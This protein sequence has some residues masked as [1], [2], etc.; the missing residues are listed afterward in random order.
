MS[1]IFKKLTDEREVMDYVK[2]HKEIFNLS[3][4]EAYPASFFSMLIRKEHPLGIV[5][6]CYVDDELKGVAVGLASPKQKSVYIP[7]AG[8][9]K[10]FQGGR[11]AFNLFM[12]L[13]ENAFNEGYESIFGI[14]DPLQSNVGK[15]HTHLGSVFNKIVTDNTN[16][17][18]VVKLIFEA[19]VKKINGQDKI[20]SSIKDLIKSIPV[21]DDIGSKHN[22]LLLQIPNNFENL[23]AERLAEAKE[24]RK[25]AN[26]IF[27]YYID[28]QNYIVTKCFS[29]KVNGEKKTYYLFEKK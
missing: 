6:G 25:K 19:S 14:I 8:I 5:I 18:P 20:H 4:L 15:V 12:T 10:E 29:Q 7:F 22:K 11:A 23:K 17:E 28:D 1:V 16:P 2:V 21:I 27:R 26:R 13:R 24:F 3:E 9:K